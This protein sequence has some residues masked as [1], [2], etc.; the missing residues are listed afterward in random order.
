MI[1]RKGV[2]HLLAVVLFVSLL[3]LA[4]STGANRTFTPDKLK[5]WLAQSG[6]YDQV[7]PAILKSEHFYR[8]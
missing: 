6:I 8:W 4:V 7:V 3:G 2:V 5:G 1:F